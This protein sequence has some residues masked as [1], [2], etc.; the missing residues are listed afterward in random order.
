MVEV[1]KV[2]SSVKEDYEDEISIRL[3][4]EVPKG[5]R[6]GESVGRVL[7]MGFNMWLHAN[8]QSRSVEIHPDRRRL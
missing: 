6:T 2:L 4:S 3:G 5:E 1:R 8:H 7:R